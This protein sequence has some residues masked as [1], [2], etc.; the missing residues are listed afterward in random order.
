ME[1]RLEVGGFTDGSPLA[2]EFVCPNDKEVGPAD[3]VGT[4]CGVDKP[5]N[6]TMVLSPAAG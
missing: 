5:L 4:L 3:E 6:G 2:G 1:Q